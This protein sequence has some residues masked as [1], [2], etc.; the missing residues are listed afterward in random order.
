MD[1]AFSDEHG[2]ARATIAALLT[3]DLHRKI[4]AY[5][6]SQGSAALEE[7]ASLRR[8]QATPPL[9]APV[10][11]LGQRVSPKKKWYLMQGMT[12]V[13]AY[14][15]TA[16]IDDDEM[17]D[18]IS[19][20]AGIDKDVAEGLAERVITEDDTMGA[21][22]QRILKSILQAPNLD[23]DSAFALGSAGIT[24]AKALSDKL[25]PGMLSSNPKDNLYELQLLGEGLMEL[26]A[27]AAY[28]AVGAIEEGF[29]DGSLEA[30]D[31]FDG[32]AFY[33]HDEQG[34]PYTAASAI[35]DS[36]GIPMDVNEAGDPIPISE[37]ATLAGKRALAA[38]VLDAERARPSPYHVYGAQNM[39]QGGLFGKAFKKLK[40]LGKKATGFV[41]S[42]LPMAGAAVGTLYGG[43][44]G[45]MLG[46][47]L[48]SS[49]GGVLSKVAG[50]GRGK[51]APRLVQAGVNQATQAMRVL[52]PQLGSTAF[53]HVM[54]NA[55]GGGRR[56]SPGRANAEIP[57]NPMDIY[58]QM[59]S[60]MRSQGYN[61]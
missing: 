53:S 59:I 41:S 46:S 9:T 43:P 49:M 15:A 55:A 26:E 31:P 27:R 20:G 33:G 29:A 6:N 7:C 24:A 13:M 61:V 17:T 54:R 28:Q 21:T 19:K 51:K 35:A 58:T 16:D 4:I 3:P 22:A 36:L 32:D 39:E 14:Y 23:A 37:D 8:S 12:C 60:F 57:A 50:S 52:S 2:E 42:A 11:L 44:A 34:D 38:F 10:T 47:Q 1:N 18:I 30:G 5:H 48:G 45:T 56:F 40:K 25:N